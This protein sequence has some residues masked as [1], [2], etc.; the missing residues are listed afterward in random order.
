MLVPQQQL[1]AVD[2]TKIFETAEQHLNNAWDSVQVTQRM[3][4]SIERGFRHIGDWTSGFYPGILWI[5][6]EQLGKDSLLQK[7]QQASA[8]IEEEKYNTKDH[9][10]GFR[11]YCPY[12]RGYK[13]TQDPHYKDVIVQAAKSAIQRYNPAV[14][15]IQS[16]E[17]QP[18]RDWKFPVIIDNMMNLE[19]LFAA[20]K[21]T[22][23]STYYNVAINHANTTMKYQYRDGYSCSHVVDFNPNTGAFRKRDYNNGNN[24]P[25]TAAWSRGQSWG[26]YGFTMVYRETNDVRYLEHAERIAKYILTHPNMPEDMV[27]YWDYNAPEIPTLRDASAAAILASGLMEL[28][29]YSKENGQKYFEAGEKI[30]TSLASPKYLAEPYTN[31]DFIIKHATGN[32]LKNSEKD[33][34]LI[35]ADYYFLEGLERYLELKKLKCE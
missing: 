22:N 34:T 4:R 17:A 20:T 2:V 26:L 1:S 35:Y 3:P 16:W 8:I 14:K 5:V 27:P 18:K 28:S 29:K 23:D 13:L 31:G 30:L 24:D 15:A 9:D 6:Y 10:I 21:I 25:S 33:G 12:G 7:A 11:I 32:F 19:L